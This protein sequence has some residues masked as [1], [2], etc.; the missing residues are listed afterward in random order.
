MADLPSYYLGCL[1][2]SWDAFVV[3][4]RTGLAYLQPGWPAVN[5]GRSSF[6]LDTDSSSLK[7][8]IWPEAKLND[9]HDGERDQ[10]RDVYTMPECREGI[11][12][13]AIFPQPS[14][15]AASAAKPRLL[16][17]FSRCV[18]AG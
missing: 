10:H 15:E 2:R 16:N 12:R 7:A 11:R 17:D 6:F 13:S 18:L 3:G 5:A 14:Y 9:E 1:L 8:R 4:R